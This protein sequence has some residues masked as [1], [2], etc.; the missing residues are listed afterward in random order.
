MY[1]ITKIIDIFIV[2]IN[3]NIVLHPDNNFP[4][5]LFPVSSQHCLMHSTSVSLHKSTGLLWIATKHGISSCS[6][7]RHPPLY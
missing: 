6:K 7:T 4:S 5:P 1:L 3:N 2:I